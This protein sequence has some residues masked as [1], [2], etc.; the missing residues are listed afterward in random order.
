MSGRALAGYAGLLQG[1]KQL[2]LGLVLFRCELGTDS[3]EKIRTSVKK[4]RD[5][6][7]VQYQMPNLDD[8]SSDAFRSAEVFWDGITF[9]RCLLEICGLLSLTLPGIDMRTFI[10]LSLI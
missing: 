5:N 7:I 6:F 10:V 3:L 4:V 1:V 9:I 2:F 8:E